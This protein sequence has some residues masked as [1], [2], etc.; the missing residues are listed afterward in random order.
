M[1]HFLV[2]VCTDISKHIRPPQ[3]LSIHEYGSAWRRHDT[4]HVIV[5][6]LELR[7]KIVLT[8]HIASIGGIVM[9]LRNRDSPR[10][11]LSVHPQ[12]LSTRTAHF[13]VRR[14]RHIRNRTG[15][16][17][18]DEDGG[19]R[20]GR[21]GQTGGCARE[22]GVGVGRVWDALVGRGRRRARRD[23]GQHALSTLTS[24]RADSG[25]GTRERS[26]RPSEIS[27]TDARGDGL[28]YATRLEPRGTARV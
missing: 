15:R 27:A 19:G 14:T 28:V 8:L 10:S 17:G 22:I 18:I 20:R 16:F 1:P 25:D 13:I 21:G 5:Q 2:C 7:N 11:I 23:D 26:D 24:R 3:R 9:V 6:R 4:P 12:N